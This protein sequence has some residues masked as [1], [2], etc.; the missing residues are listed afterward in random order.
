MVKPLGDISKL[1][2]NSIEGIR[3]LGY[4]A[5]GSSP[6]WALRSAGIGVHRFRRW[7]IRST[8]S[9]GHVGERS[10]VAS[11]GGRPLQTERICR[12]SGRGNGRLLTCGQSTATG[13]KFLQ[14]FWQENGRPLGCGR[15]T[16]GQSRRVNTWKLILNARPMDEDS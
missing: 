2:Q 15:S 9:G 11:V 4:L 12:G 6:G 1:A 3:E 14:W 16:V 5:L 13:R 7:L 8:S 10:T